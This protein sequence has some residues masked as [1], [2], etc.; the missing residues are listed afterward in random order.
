MSYKPAPKFPVWAALEHAGATD[1]PRVKGT[2]YEWMLCPFHPDSK[3]S[4]HVSEFGFVCFAC[5]VQGDAI[6][7]VRRE[8]LNYQG[9][10]AILKELTG[11]ADRDS[12]PEREWGQSLLG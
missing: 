7:L 8:G 3:P 1:V 2:R 9:A 6:K 4:A 11:G 10:I 5:G 12:A